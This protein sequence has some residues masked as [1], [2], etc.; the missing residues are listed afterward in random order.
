MLHTH[1]PGNP[2]L[3]KLTLIKGRV[4]FNCMCEKE[5]SVP[6]ALGVTFDSPFSPVSTTK[7]KPDG[8]LMYTAIYCQSTWGNKEQHVTADL[9]PEA[10]LYGNH[11][12]VPLRERK[13]ESLCRVGVGTGCVLLYLLRLSRSVWQKAQWFS[14]TEVQV[15]EFNLSRLSKIQITPA[16]GGTAICLFKVLLKTACQSGA[17]WISKMSVLLWNWLD[18]GLHINSR[19]ET[20]W[21]LSCQENNCLYSTEEEVPIC[22]LMTINKPPSDHRLWP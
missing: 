12:H 2:Y 13:R 11:P 21:Q 3:C 20:F 18:R 16:F 10:L 4:D 5:R 19:R 1:E 22:N 15:Q 8:H 14:V 17:F 6:S 7:A 9:S